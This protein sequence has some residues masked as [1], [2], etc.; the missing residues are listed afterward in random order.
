L[1]FKEVAT[2]TQ[3]SEWKKQGLKMFRNKFYE[4]ALKCFQQAQE[5]ILEDR[6]KAYFLAEAASKA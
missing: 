2:K 3:L 5:P 6:A 4:Q 1:Q